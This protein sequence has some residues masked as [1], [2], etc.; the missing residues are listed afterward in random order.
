MRYVLHQFL[1][2]VRRRRT[3][4]VIH[5]VL[6]FLLTWLVWTP[7]GVEWIE[8]LAVIQNVYFMLH[9]VLL[10]AAG[11][12]ALESGCADS[13]EGTNTFWRTRP[14]RW[15]AVWRGKLV[16]VTVAIAGPV[17]LCWAVNGLML[18]QTLA[19]WRAGLIEPLCAVSALLVLTGLRSLARGWTAALI[20]FGIAVGLITGGTTLLAFVDKRIMDELSGWGSRYSSSQMAPG[21]YILVGFV[22]PAV[23]IVAFWAAAMRR[24]VRRLASIS[25]VIGVVLGPL[26]TWLLVRECLARRLQIE[27]AVPGEVSAA[28]TRVLGMLKLH[29]VP[30]DREVAFDS[31]SI[32]TEWVEVPAGEEEN[33]PKFRLWRENYRM[34]LQPR[35]LTS[36]AGQRLRSH[37]PAATRWYSDGT[38][39]ASGSPGFFALDSSN[40]VRVTLHGSAVGH[41]IA[42]A[43][44]LAVRLEN[45]AAGVGS[46]TRIRIHRVSGGSRNLEVEFAIWQT[47][48]AFRE[49]SLVTEEVLILHLPAVPAALLL[50]DR[51]AHQFRS[52]QCASSRKALRI[53][54]PD[55]EMVRGVRFTPETMRGAELWFFAPGEE[56]LFEA[57]PVEG[58]VMLYPQRRR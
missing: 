11:L 9:V 4:L 57:T 24:Q 39:D 45:D 50:N 23:A 21:L 25:A 47:R 14:P 36:R 55:A 1:W 15:L 8:N 41:L 13:A 49:E 18:H 46:G 33:P 28:D 42:P 17:L 30:Q 10:V 44:G 35:W 48:A 52:L 37:F 53:T 26:L 2:Q 51:G 6:W 12:L 31:D 22:V 38:S 16:F 7:S 43:Q 54:M 3:L 58:P 29:G 40:P 56:T 27:P 19:Q 5:A 32:T 34:G 20:V